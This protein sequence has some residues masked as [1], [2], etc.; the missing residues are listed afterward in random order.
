MPRAPTKTA[1]SSVAS[2][3]RQCMQVRGRG[4]IRKG[5]HGTQTHRSAHGY[6]RMATSSA[7]VLRR[8]F[9]QG[10]RE[11]E[12]RLVRAEKLNA[13]AAAEQPQDSPGC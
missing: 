6:R 1:R 11:I 5:S 8:V 10:E 7:A 4:R 13:A 9:W 3:E 12:R 2:S